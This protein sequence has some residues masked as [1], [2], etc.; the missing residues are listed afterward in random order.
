MH[1]NREVLPGHRTGAEHTVTL[2][3]H[4]LCPVRHPST[5]SM[6]Q[7]VQT[8]VSPVSSNGKSC[9]VEAPNKLSPTQDTLALHRCQL[10]GIYFQYIYHITN[11]VLS[12][13]SWGC[14]SLL[15]GISHRTPPACFCNL[16]P[17]PKKFYKSKSLQKVQSSPQWQRF[18]SVKWLD[19]CLHCV[20]PKIFHHP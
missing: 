10:E 5:C 9:P 13:I 4:T 15:W 8:K 12:L 14:R 17:C 19:T 20:S 18:R 6:G 3:C 16:S 11:L 1:T 7:R 2:H